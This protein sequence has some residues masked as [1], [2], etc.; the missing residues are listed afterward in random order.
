MFPLYGGKCSLRKAFYNWVEEF[1]QGCMKVADDAQPGHP[2]DI[3]TEAT[4]QWVEEL[5]QADR[6][7]TI[8][9]VAAA[10]GC[11]HGLAY[12][13]MHDRVKFRE[14][15]ARWVPRELKYREKMNRNGLSLHLLRYV[16][17][18]KYCSM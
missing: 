15:C 2:V 8:D 5:I 13:T 11:S 7:I 18:R 6:R 16:D 1:S 10:L 17:E 3:A 12:S 14:V 4:V 9:S